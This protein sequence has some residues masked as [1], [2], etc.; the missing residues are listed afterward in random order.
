MKFSE[1]IDSQ[2]DD[3]KKAGDGY[4][5]LTDLSKG[6]IDHAVERYVEYRMGN[7]LNDMYETTKKLDSLK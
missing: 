5:A 4:D 3:L 6:V 2:K 1:F 7:T